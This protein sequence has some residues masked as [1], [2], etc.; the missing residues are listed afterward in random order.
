MTDFI[1]VG[2]KG[3]RRCRICGIHP[4]SVSESA[5]HV[6]EFHRDWWGIRPVTTPPWAREDV[7]EDAPVDIVEDIVEGIGD[8]VDEVTA[9]ITEAVDAALEEQPDALPSVGFIDYICQRLLSAEQRLV[10]TQGTLVEVQAELVTKQ[11]ELDR[12]HQLLG[13]LN[14]DRVSVEAREVYQDYQNGR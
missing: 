4:A 5:N 3:Y 11:S 2:G 9:K 7:T 14:S 12:T 8:I 13:A 1:I 10:E 6:Y